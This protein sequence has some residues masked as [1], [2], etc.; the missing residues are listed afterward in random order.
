MPAVWDRLT[1]LKIPVTIVVGSEDEKFRAT[2]R[3]MHKR[4]TWAKVVVVAGAG[5]ALPLEAPGALAR[6]ILA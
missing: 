5:H 6:E 2:A 1:H 3:R 4:M